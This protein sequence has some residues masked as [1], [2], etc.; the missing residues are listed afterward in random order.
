MAEWMIVAA[1]AAAR[2]GR[3]G[4]PGLGLACVSADGRW[5]QKLLTSSQD[6]LLGELCAIEL[7]LEMG[8]GP[9]EVLSDAAYALSW[10]ERP[11]SATTRAREYAARR[12]R[13]AMRH[14]DVRLVWVKGHSGHPL[15]DAADRL[16]RAALIQ[17]EPALARQL[18]EQIIVDQLGVPASRVQVTARS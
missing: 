1:D 9:I 8:R 12:I 11:G 2:R 18:A 10:I 5:R 16:A 15:H 3:L 4:T 14:R 7:A 13:V 17:R 6:N